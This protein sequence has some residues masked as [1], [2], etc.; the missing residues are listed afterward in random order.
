MGPERAVHHCFK[1]VSR[2]FLEHSNL[3]T[4]VIVTEEFSTQGKLGNV[5]KS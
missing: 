1:A 5:L 4:A 3:Q 2:P